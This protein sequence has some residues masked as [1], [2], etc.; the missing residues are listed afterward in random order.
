MFKHCLIAVVLVLFCSLPRAWG[1]QG[2]G[3]IRGTVI[4][5]TDGQPLPRA[6]AQLLDTKLGAY[7]DMQGVFSVRRVPS[8]RYTLRVSYAGYQPKEIGGIVVSGGVV[9]VDVA[10]SRRRDSTVISVRGR[11]RS[12]TEEALLRQRQGAANVSDGISQVQIAKLADPTGADALSRVTGLTIV[13]QR[14]A[15]IRGASE[16]YNNTQLNGVTIVGTDP[17]KRAFSFDLIPANLLEN[18]VVLK[19]FTPDLPG[20]FSGGLVRM[21]TVDFPDI[22]TARLSISSSYTGGVTFRTVNLGPRGATDYLGIDDGLR[23]LPSVFNDT[24]PLSRENISPERRAE[25]ASLLPNTFHVRPV[26]AS[27][28]LSLTGSWGDRASFGEEGDVGVVAGFSY[29]NGWE[30]NAIQR[31]DT[32]LYRYSGTETSYS[33]LWGGLLNAALK[34]DG[35]NT[36]SIRNLYNRTADDELTMVSGRLLTSDVEN[37]MWVFRYLERSFY[38]GQLSGEHL[39]PQVPGLRVD[40]K[41]FYTRG[42]RDEPDLRRISYVRPFGDTTV[43]LQNTLSATLPNPYGTGR[44]YSWLDEESGGGA[45]DLLWS[46]EN[47][48][49]KFGALAEHRDRAFSSRS[50]SYLLSN[51]SRSLA[52]ADLD[53]L[54]NPDHFGVDALTLTESTSPSDR[55]EGQSRLSAGYGMVDLPIEVAGERFRAILGA[56]YEDSRVLISTVDPNGLPLQ[57][58]Y[59]TFDWLPSINLTWSLLPSS[60][61]RLAWSR[62]VSRPDFREY[63]RYVF[64]DYITDALTYGNP[65]LRRTV[66]FNSDIRFE[67]FPDAGELL[68]LSLFRKEFTDAI[69]EVGLNGFSPERTWAN[70]DGTTM[71]IELEFRKRL[72]II[73][74]VLEPLSLNVNTTILDSKV[75]LDSTRFGTQLQERPLQGQSPFIVNIGLFYDNDSSGTSISLAYNRFGRRLVRVARTE[76]PDYFEEGR[77]RIDLTLSQTLF[78]TLELRVAARDLLASDVVVNQYEGGVPARIDGRGPSVSIGVAFRR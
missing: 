5:A 33:V 29:R 62:T 64:Y 54:F 24:L 37:H 7:S 6:T 74:D 34:I 46:R 73:A 35:N 41:G 68:A 13:G 58:D 55:Y 49:L 63:A 66:V 50:F 19:T 3:E 15:Q 69:E 2:E 65:D 26:T 72:D 70:A 53:T 21:Q 39:L 57:V 25:L 78:A 28:G 75:Q 10:L 30:S 18:S 12:G 36:V 48:R 17:G 47:L 56:R 52:T 9:R 23:A 45:I 44:V 43:P 38:S 40:W 14:F 22:A 67:I 51:T 27:P 59:R 31:Y 32:F 8:G 20:D 42:E 76:Q 60:N 61:L 11:R 1:Q 77:D 4:D 71:G 16:R